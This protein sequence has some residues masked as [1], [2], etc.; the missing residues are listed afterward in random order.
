ML[1]TAKHS[2]KEDTEKVTR[3]QQQQHLM[4]LKVIAGILGVPLGELTQRDKEYQLEMN[5]AVPAE[6]EVVDRD[7]VDRCGRRPW[8]CRPNG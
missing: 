4:L 3:C 2:T 5:R 1:S 8:Q 7:P 6:S